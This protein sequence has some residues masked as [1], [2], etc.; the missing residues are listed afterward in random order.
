MVNYRDELV[1]HHTDMVSAQRILVPIKACGG[2][3]FVRV[4][5]PKL[6]VPLHLQPEQSLNPSSKDVPQLNVPLSSGGWIASSKRRYNSLKNVKVVNPR[7]AQGII[8]VVK[9][10]YS[11]AFMPLFPFGLGPWISALCTPRTHF[12]PKLA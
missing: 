3:R 9:W 8:L 5:L 6:I 12:E 7:R 11:F 4:A 1:Q 2:D 10:E